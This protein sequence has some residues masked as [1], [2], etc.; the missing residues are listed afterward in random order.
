MG[1]DGLIQYT[2]GCLAKGGFGVSVQHLAKG[3]IWLKKT[4]GA[5]DEHHTITMSSGAN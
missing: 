5:K 4:P 1:W 2:L 3:D